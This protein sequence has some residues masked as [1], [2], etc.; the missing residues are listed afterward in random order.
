MSSAIKAQLQLLDADKMLSNVQNV[1]QVI[2]I[3]WGRIFLKPHAQVSD[4]VRWMNFG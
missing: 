3:E 2:K 4:R 1:G